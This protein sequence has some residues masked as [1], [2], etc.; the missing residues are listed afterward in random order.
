MSAECN[1]TQAAADCAASWFPA[2]LGT[3]LTVQVTNA[4]ALLLFP[5]L[6]AL[7]FRLMPAG[8]NS[9]PVSEGSMQERASNLLVVLMGGLVGWGLALFWVPFDETEKSVYTQVGAT[10]SAFVAGYALSKF[11]K[12]LEATLFQ[13]RRPV[14]I[15]VIRI[16]LFFSSLG[17]AAVVIIT[18]RVTW[19]SEDNHKKRRDPTELANAAADAKVKAIAAEAAARAAADAASAPGRR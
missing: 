10:V 5:M 9:K 13:D 4:A 7:A 16:G 12:V 18:N 8:T 17:L 11:D 14:R 19:L 3:T 15:T 1:A 6:I 2:V